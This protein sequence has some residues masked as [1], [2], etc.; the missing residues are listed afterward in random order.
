M[1]N[2]IIDIFN[3]HVAR[4]KHL[5]VNRREKL[6]RKSRYYS[7]VTTTK[8]VDRVFV[9]SIIRCF[10]KYTRFGVPLDGTFGVVISCAAA[11]I[12]QVYCGT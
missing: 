4:F 1:D 2:S 12:K 3:F 8:R 10:Q 11:V 6:Y 7:T 9:R 5:R